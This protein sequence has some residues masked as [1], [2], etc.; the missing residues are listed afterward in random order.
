L[1]LIFRIFKLGALNMLPRALQIT[2]APLL[3]EPELFRRLAALA[4]L[5][6]SARR[7]F[8][9]QLRDPDLSARDLLRLGTRLRDT[10]AAFGA[11]LFV[12]DRLDL[13]RI[14]GADGIHLG[15]RS[16]SVADARAF[17]PRDTLVSVACHSIADVLRAAS[18][19]ADV[20]VL[21]PIFASPGKGAPLGVAVLREAKHELAARGLAVHLVALG[22]VD[23]A[24]A[25]SC[26]AAGAD[27]VSAIRADLTEVLRGGEG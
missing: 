27:A 20:A 25:G 12:N 6:P 22:G 24:N 3:P 1:R 17:L 10:T 14:L 5:P 13:A 26:F 7:L 8:A 9:V 19:G 18:D 21:S 16:V 15:R 23:V 11:A 4:S 2:A